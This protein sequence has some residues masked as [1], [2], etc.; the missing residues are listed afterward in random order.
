MNLRDVA[1]VDKLFLNSEFT[2]YANSASIYISFFTK[3]S[4]PLKYKSG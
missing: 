1:E 3:K 2:A 4:H